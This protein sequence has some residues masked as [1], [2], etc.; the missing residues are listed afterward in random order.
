MF[1]K[2]QY[3]IMMLLG[4]C[5]TLNVLAFMVSTVIYFKPIT[6]NK[7]IHDL[8]CEHINVSDMSSPEWT[9]NGDVFVKNKCQTQ[10]LRILGQFYFQTNKTF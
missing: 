1:E 6:P 4:F 9:V 8:E 3:I 5:F 10:R 2:H 7:T